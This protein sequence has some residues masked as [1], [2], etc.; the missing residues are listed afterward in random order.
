M[1]EAH[2]GKLTLAVFSDIPVMV[3][4]SLYESSSATLMTTT[5][6]CF[7]GNFDMASHSSLFSH[8]FATLVSFFC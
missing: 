1:F 3:D 8:S 5:L 4:I 7:L 2:D 6:R